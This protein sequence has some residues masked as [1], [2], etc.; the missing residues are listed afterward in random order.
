M[1]AK[2]ITTLSLDDDPQYKAAAA[3]RNDLLLERGKVETKYYAVLNEL[4]AMSID[5]PRRMDA[6]TAAA[7]KLLGNSNINK[8]PSENVSALQE[9]LAAYSQ[10]R[11]VFDV[12]IQIQ[13]Q[14]ID[15]ARSRASG[16]VVAQMAPAHRE[17]VRE[18]AKCLMNLDAAL[19]AEHEL[20]DGLREKGVLLGS[21]SPMPFPRL[22]R[23]KDPNS[24]A[25]AWLLEAVEHGFISV[26]ELPEK[27][28]EYGKAKL[29]KQ[30]PAPSPA[31]SGDNDGWIAA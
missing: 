13:R 9:N 16:H 27:L 24:S 6:I 17:L 19:A 26:P 29:H 4:N 10:Q 22:G 8:T 21:M 14:T 31:L 11:D 30:N 5:P 12:A 15:A 20:C 2:T 18:I 1:S 23:L 3:Q 7:Y 28:R 25:S